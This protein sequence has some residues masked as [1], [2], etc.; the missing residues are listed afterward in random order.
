MGKAV[1]D[2]SQR[3]NRMSANLILGSV[4]GAV[5]LG[6][7]GCVELET[8]VVTADR[9]GGGRA[10]ERRSVAKRNASLAGGGECRKR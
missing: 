2:S 9:A 8:R 5:V 3:V 6:T 7:G 10:E 1:T 4:A